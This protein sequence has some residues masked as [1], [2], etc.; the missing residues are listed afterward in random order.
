MIASLAVLGLV[1]ERQDTGREATEEISLLWGRRQTLV[2]PMLIKRTLVAGLPREDYVLPHSLKY[3]TTLVPEI[4]SRG[5]FKTVVYKSVV[6]VEGQF[7]RGDWAPVFGDESA[8][9]FSLGISDTRGIERQFNLQ[10]NNATLAFESGAGVDLRAMSGLHATVPLR[11]VPEMIPFSFDV[12]L[13]GSEGVS[14]APLGRETVIAMT[15]SWPTPKFVGAFLPS[16]H[17]IGRDG[18][19]AEWRISSFGRSYP[20]S[21]SKDEVGFDQVILSAAGVD[22]HQSIDI[23]DMVFRSVK[24]AVLFI[25]ITFA[26]FFLFDVLG[27]IRVHPIQ[28]L[29]I[30]AALA[31]F[32]LLLLSFS[33]QIGFLAAYL[34]AMLMIAG[35]VTSYSW[36]VLRSGKR[37]FLIGILLAALY[38]YL[39]FVL[40]LEDYALLAGSLAL[41]LLLGGAMYAT[42]NID[43]FSLEKNG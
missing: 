31:L 33:E 29:L 2:G 32:Y 41:F 5:I 36:F 9:L 12:E 19:N 14:V 10:W 13:K 39:Y 18:F 6:H 20:Q 7:K 28:Y 42:R 26:A 23:Y 30:G 1:A 11:S 25:V 4:R 15:S 24:Y 21:F 37:A 43:W 22:L 8:G 40:Q 34:L 27:S 35:L 17:E 3:K 38:S 16:S